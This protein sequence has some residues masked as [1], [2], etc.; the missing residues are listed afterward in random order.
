MANVSPNRTPKRKEAQ[1]Q[2]GRN[3]TQLGNCACAYLEETRH[4][5]HQALVCG[6]AATV[7]AIRHEIVAQQRSVHQSLRESI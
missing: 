1:N 4:L 5:A 3:W 2:N 6:L 7:V